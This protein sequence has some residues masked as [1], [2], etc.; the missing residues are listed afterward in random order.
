VT[1]ALEELKLAYNKPDVFIHNA[2][3]LVIEPLARTSADQFEQYSKG[4]VLY[5]MRPE[6]V[7]S[8]YVIGFHDLLPG[9]RR[10]SF[11]FAK[12]ASRFINLEL[13]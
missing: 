8:R 10:Y 12:D 5:H 4:D 11:V 7:P 1:W 13:L 9:K 2:A 6:E 3:E